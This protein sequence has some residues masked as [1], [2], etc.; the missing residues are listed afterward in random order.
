VAHQQAGVPR[1]D[2][3]H[4]SARHARRRLFFC[5]GLPVFIGGLVGIAAQVVATATVSRPGA[6]ALAVAVGIAAALSVRLVL[7]LNDRARLG[8]ELA[9][10][11]QHFRSLVQ[12]SS[13]LITVCDEVGIIT[14][15][16][17]AVTSVF[18]YDPDDML[19]R[20]ITD[21]VHLEDVRD[22]HRRIGS[23][24]SGESDGAIRF[25]CRVRDGR[26]TWVE[27][28]STVTDHRS[29]ASVRGLVLNTRD[30]SDRAELEGRLTHLVHHD[31]LTD[32]PNRSL[33]R[34][35]VRHL[36]E[37]RHGHDQPV[38]VLVVDLDGFKAVNEAAGHAAG[39]TLLVQC[40]RRLRRLVRG[41]D[42]LARLDG[43]SFAVLLEDE[44]ERS[45][46]LDIAQRLLDALNAPY[47]VA[48]REH[49]VGASVGVAFSGP[50]TG[51]DELLID[52]E[53]ALRAAKRAGRNRVEVFVPEM[54]LEAVRRVE[55]EAD[56]RRALR[57]GEF[58]LDYQPVLDLHS[59]FVVGVEALLRWNH[60]RRGWV[61][62]VE[63]IPVAEE[64]GLIVPLGRWILEEACRQVARWRRAGYEL[65]LAVNLSARQLSAPGLVDSVASVLRM[66]GL[67]ASALTLEI[68]E[69]VLVDTEDRTLSKLVL[70]R[71]LGARLAIDDFGTG[72]S[73]LSYLQRLPVDVLKIDRSYIAGLG[74][75]P[76]MKSLTSTIIHLGQE[77]GLTVV[78]EGIE[79]TE[80]RDALLDMGC[81]LGQGFL[82]A[83]PLHAEDVIRMLS[84]HGMMATPPPQR[85]A[86]AMAEEHQA[87]VLRLR[88]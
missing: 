22:V 23:L 78:A 84:E 61:P 52:A 34:D 76:E 25:E 44:D 54:H 27:T 18:G 73:S 60:P 86:Q 33:F 49:V 1:T 43:D 50:N 7:M 29:N 30:I 10:R 87:Q 75:K 46:A 79:E 63:V 64:S 55:L 56:I 16:S 5:V 62:P 42:T 65:D 48:G 72:Y 40:A 47:A 37:G 36:L 39:D 82:F 81:D 66:A 20:R 53:L 70:L 4:A 17:P 19:G 68:T 71:E 67:P 57:A 77:L 15:C 69:N 31:P 58:S 83:Q 85:E 8:A 21:M 59:G 12:A 51:A 32:L 11:E 80:Q 35:R 45:G 88:A 38:T 14:Y 24:L 41:G 6:A 26:G 9:E 3:A 74:Y 28:E 13:D 2:T